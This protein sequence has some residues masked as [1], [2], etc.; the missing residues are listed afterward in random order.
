V[1][2]SPVGIAL[3]QSFEGCRLS[4]YDD[5]VGVMTIGYGHTGKDVKAG[6]RISQ[7]EADELLEKDLE[8]FEK[9]VEKAVKGASGGT[10][11]SQFDA[12]VSLAFNIGAAA[13]AKSSVCS[14][15]NAGDEEK[16]GASFLLW[17]KAGGRKLKGL[18]RRRRAESDL[19]LSA[20]W[21][22]GQ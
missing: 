16:A 4:A 17:D 14:A 5:G 6:M 19:Y 3:I 2:I 20:R 13:F 21:R 12:M 1:K 18:E 9:A 10:N 7:A 15:H 11:Q 22:M 8:R